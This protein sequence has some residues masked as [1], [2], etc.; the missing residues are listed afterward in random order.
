MN[1][2]NCII[3]EPN[4]TSHIKPYIN[5]NVRTFRIKYH[6]NAMLHDDYL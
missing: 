2:T 1:I 3:K 6:H 5:S 4:H